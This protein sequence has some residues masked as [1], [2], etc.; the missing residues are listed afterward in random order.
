MTS[1]TIASVVVNRW[2][3]GISQIQPTACF[4][5]TH[6]LTI[7]FT[8][9]NNW[10]K[11]QKRNNILWHVNI[12]WNS[13]LSASNQV[14]LAPSHPHLF[15]C[16]LWLLLHCSCRAEKLRY[17]PSAQEAS[18][19]YCPAHCRKGL[20]DWDACLCLHHT[21]GPS[22]G[23]NTENEVLWAPFS[24]HSYK[25]HINI[26]HVHERLNIIKMHVDSESHKSSS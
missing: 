25:P 1:V 10:K 11:N 17:R 16:Y 21:R 19:I 9:L 23:A 20:P 15:T 6:E 5:I 26:I 18:S 8:F 7:I 22:A 24:L 4:C 2:R 3:P 14:W 13:N 12:L